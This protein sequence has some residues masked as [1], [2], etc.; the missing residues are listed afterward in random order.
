MDIKVEAANIL[1]YFEDKYKV[2]IINNGIDENDDIYRLNEVILCTINKC[3]EFYGFDF[4]NAIEKIIELKDNLNCM[5][6]ACRFLMTKKINN[7]TGDEVFQLKIILY[8]LE[9]CSG[10][11]N[12]NANNAINMWK[13]ENDKIGQILKSIDF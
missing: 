4:D 6:K 5:E 13:R 7:L 10:L 12:F 9:M 8:V 11:Y 2:L 1:K 3:S